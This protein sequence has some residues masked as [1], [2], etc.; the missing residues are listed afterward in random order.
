MAASEDTRNIL[1]IGLHIPV[2]MHPDGNIIPNEKSKAESRN[3]NLDMYECDTSKSNDEIITGLTQ[4]L[5]SKKYVAISIGNGVRGNGDLTPLFEKLVNACIELQ[6][7]TKFGFA[8]LPTLVVEACER[9][10]Q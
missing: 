4:L 10:L 9:V 3:F 6:P 5:K 1:G 7:G 2:D 8:L